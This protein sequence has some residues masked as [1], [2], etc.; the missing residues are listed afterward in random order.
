MDQL[1]ILPTGKPFFGAYPKTSIPRREQTSNIATREM[2]TLW[3]LPRDAP[4]TIEAKQAEFRAEP[5]ITVWR[6]SN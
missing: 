1:A 3:R 6:L 5:E 4:N 2:L